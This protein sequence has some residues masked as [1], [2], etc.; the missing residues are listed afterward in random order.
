M[1]LLAKVR[2]KSIDGVFGV[3][4]LLELWSFFHNDVTCVGGFAARNYFAFLLSNVKLFAQCLG[5]S[6]TALWH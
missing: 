3:V 4:G 1:I 5:T 6:R 2:S